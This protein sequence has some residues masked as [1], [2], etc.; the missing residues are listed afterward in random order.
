MGSENRG[1]DDK[2][3]IAYDQPGEAQPSDAPN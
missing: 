2:A 1:D 3:S